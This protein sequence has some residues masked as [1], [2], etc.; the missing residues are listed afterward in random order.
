MLCLALT[1]LIRGQSDVE[2]MKP[3]HKRKLVKKPVLT[4]IKVR[5]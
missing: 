4:E 5:V 1:L 2:R 3:P